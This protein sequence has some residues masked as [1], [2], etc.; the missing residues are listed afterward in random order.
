MKK[1]LGGNTLSH[2]L[3]GGGEFRVFERSW[4]FKG[5][6]VSGLRIS[7]GVGGFVVFLCGAYEEVQT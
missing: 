3:G 1:V 2:S 6:C 7:T 4:R 5:V